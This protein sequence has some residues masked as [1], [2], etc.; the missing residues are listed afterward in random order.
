MSVIEVDAGNHVGLLNQHFNNIKEFLVSPEAQALIPKPKVT[1]H[2]DWPAIQNR[3]EKAYGP[4]HPLYGKC[5][6]GAKFILFF[7]GGKKHL[8]LKVMKKLKFCDLDVTTT[9]WFIKVKESGDIFDATKDQFCYPNF[10]YCDYDDSHP[11]WDSAKN[12]DFGFPHFSRKWWY[13]EVVPSVV[14]MHMGELYKNIYGTNGGI[15]WWIEQYKIK[16]EMT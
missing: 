14:V 6:Y 7:G 4:V 8:S 3:V 9:H 2:N 15:D 10:K 16:K 5:F 1:P 12:A 13:D 11:F